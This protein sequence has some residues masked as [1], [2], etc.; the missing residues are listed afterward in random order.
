MSTLYMGH[1]IYLS[2]KQIASLIEGEEIIADGACVPVVKESNGSTTE[3]AAEMITK[4]ALIKKGEAKILGSNNGFTISIV[5]PED[6]LPLPNGCEWINFS[7]CSNF[8]GNGII[9][10]VVIMPER[11]LFNSFIK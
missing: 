7:Q 5:R 9:H 3:P 11:S 1:S 2:E 10:Q 4:Y 8:E 6:L